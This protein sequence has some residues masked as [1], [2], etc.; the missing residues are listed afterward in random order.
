MA[1]L[2][3]AEKIADME[4]TIHFLEKMNKNLTHEV[5]S[6][7]MLLDRMGYLFRMPK[8]VIDTYERELHELACRCQERCN[9]DKIEADRKK[10]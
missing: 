9:F 8:D 1:K 5:V 4:E 10:K 2:T 3:D 7:C 6:A